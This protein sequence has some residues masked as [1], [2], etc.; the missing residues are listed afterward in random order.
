MKLTSAFFLACLVDLKQKGRP[1]IL[2]WPELRDS[3]SDIDDD[4]EDE[5]KAISAQ[6]D[7]DDS[8]IE[9]E[10]NKEEIITILRSE[11]ES[12]KTKIDDIFKVCSVSPKTVSQ[13]VAIFRFF[14]SRNLTPKDQDNT[15]WWILYCQN[16]KI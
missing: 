11:N 10:G 3:Y 13:K 6:S 16:L 8:D 14:V 12:L 9:S 15:N 4:E 1:K 7:I 2:T 5:E